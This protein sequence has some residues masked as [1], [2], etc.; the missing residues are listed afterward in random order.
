MVGKF[1][2]DNLSQDGR[3]ADLSKYY[4]PHTAL[5]NLII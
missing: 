2:K 5:E 4:K 3:L 1:K